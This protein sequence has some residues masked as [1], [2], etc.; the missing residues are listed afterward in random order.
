MRTKGDSLWNIVF[1]I[2]QWK[3]RLKEKRRLQHIV[4]MA[5]DY[6]DAL[7]DCGDLRKLLDIHKDIWGNGLQND[8][9]GPNPY[10]MF[11]TKDIKE[12]KAEEVFLG[13]IYG[14]W[15]FTIPEWEKERNQ[16]F[17]S[18]GWMIDPNITMYELVAKQYRNHLLSNVKAIKKEAEASLKKYTK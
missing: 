15:T 18:N 5:D 7:R 13:D 6:I 8:N 1:R 9:I 2:R 17:G 12:M 3:E 14:L 11:R 16:K 10:G 4:D